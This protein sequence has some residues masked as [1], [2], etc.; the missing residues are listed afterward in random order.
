MRD[1]NGHFAAGNTFARG[2]G[3]PLGNQNARGSGAPMRNINAIHHGI[4]V[5]FKDGERLE[6]RLPPGAGSDVLDMLKE[7]KKLQDHW[8]EFRSIAD[9]AGIRVAKYPY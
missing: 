3:P 8:A 6:D 9:R 1:K 7:A 5:K 4:Y 2:Y